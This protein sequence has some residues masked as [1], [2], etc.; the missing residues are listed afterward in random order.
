MNSETFTLF[1]SAIRKKHGWSQAELAKRAG[2]TQA[3]IS[4]IERG[5]LDPQLSTV[6]SILTALE[7]DVIL[8]SDAK[9]NKFTGEFD[10]E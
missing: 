1:M 4:Q 6:V 8:T 5:L 10:H 7:T 2:T 3:R 9:F